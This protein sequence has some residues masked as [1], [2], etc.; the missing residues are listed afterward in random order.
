MVTED[1]LHNAALEAEQSLLQTLS[2]EAQ[3]HQFSE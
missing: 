1:M 3:S 2:E